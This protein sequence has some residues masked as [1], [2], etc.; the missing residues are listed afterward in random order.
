MNILIPMAG[1]GLRLK[2]SDISVPKPLIEVDGLPMFHKVTNSIKIDG[3]FHYVVRK[4]HVDNYSIDTMIWKINAGNV[5]IATEDNN[6]QV[7]TCLL[8]KESINNDEPLLIVNCDNYFVWNYED[9]EDLL[10]NPDIDG[11]AF[12]FKDEQKRSHWCFAQVDEDNFITKLVE[13]NPVSDIALAG[14]FYWRKGSDFVRYAEQLVEE[15]IRT[16]NG[17]FYLGSVFNLAI[18][19][20]KQIFNYPI[21]DMKS[22]GTPEE[23][24]HFKDWVKDKNEQVSVETL[25]RKGKPMKNRNIQNA[26]D[27]LRAGK[28]IVVI[29]EHDRENEGD[30]VL[31]AEKA[32]K[33]NLIFTINKAK[34]LMCVPCLGELLDKLEIP[35]MV[36]NNTD[37]NETP[38][39]VSVDAVEG[40]TTGMAVTDRLSTIAVFLDEWGKPTDLNRPGHLFPLRAKPG[41][42]KERRGHTEAS[43]ELM[44]LAG[45]KPIAIIC[46]IMT[47]R[48]TMAKGGEINK[49]ATEN[50]LTLISIE[51]IYE[52]V[53][54]E[55]L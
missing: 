47:D 48:G 28:P 20:G 32:N 42:L 35:P 50:G 51:E 22:F 53:Y 4:E 6:G 31:S 38:F 7:E 18:S 10:D 9:F 23:L 15:D 44:Q 24:Q 39:A 43:V 1:K 40:T 33:E 21:E 54:G 14:G 55:S 49:F 52:E 3:D 41:L 36:T 17:E 2:N 26:I 46:E 27:E 16:G 25:L 5:Y 37:V 30:I 34:G 8:A 13:K 12:T 29:D 45:L 19:D 11:A